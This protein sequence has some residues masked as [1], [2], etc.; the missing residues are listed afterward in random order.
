LQGSIERAEH[1]VDHGSIG[2]VINTLLAVRAALRARIASDEVRGSGHTAPGP[3]KRRLRRRYEASLCSMQHMLDRALSAE[4]RDS[5]DGC[6]RDELARIRRL[7]SL[8]H[9][10]VLDEHW[11]DLGVGD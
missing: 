6:I 3:W 8:E 9:Q 5:L 4:E 10:A 7:A 2:A 1:A 11:L